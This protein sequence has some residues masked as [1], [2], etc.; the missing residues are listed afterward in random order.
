MIHMFGKTV[1]WGNQ[2]G[3]VVA[4][5]QHESACH[6][7]VINNHVQRM[8]YMNLPNNAKLYFSFFQLLSE[9]NILKN[10]NL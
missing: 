9:N 8:L 10:I 2:D 7:I 3:K 5:K 4:H 1:S 6:S